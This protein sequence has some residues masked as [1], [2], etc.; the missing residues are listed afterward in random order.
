MRETESEVLSK[1]RSEKLNVGAKVI[2]QPATVQKNSTV[3]FIALA[4]IAKD[5][6]DRSTELR[7]WNQTNVLID[8]KKDES[9]LVETELQLGTDLDD[10]ACQSTDS[11]SEVNFLENNFSEGE[12]EIETDC[13]VVSDLEED[14]LQQESRIREQPVSDE[15]TAMTNPMRK[16]VVTAVLDALKIKRDSGVSIGIFEDILKYP[17]K[18]V[19]STL[20]NTTIDRDILTILWPKTWNDVQSLLREEGY[21]DAKQFY[22]C[23]CRQKKE[24]MILGHQS[25]PTVESTA[26]WRVKM[27]FVPTV[28]RSL[29]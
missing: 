22:I 24:M 27:I 6:P 11:E 5:G 25:I 10:S 8:H 15:P 19:L 21:E 7:H 3:M 28:E 9:Q 20:D 13:S 12:E 4:Q 16:L 2:F 29:T 23:I 1:W 17:K 18:L 26:L 14:L